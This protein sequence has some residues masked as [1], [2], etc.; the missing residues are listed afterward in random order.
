MAMAVVFLV[1]A[2]NTRLRS[3]QIALLLVGM[4]SSK[5][6]SGVTGAGS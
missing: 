1:Q 4:I 2:P 6:A 3:D 5:G